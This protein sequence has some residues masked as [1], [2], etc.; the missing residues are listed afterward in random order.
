[1]FMWEENR[2]PDLMKKYMT[3]CVLCPRMC[4]VN[5]LAGQTGFC[6]ETAELV[7][8][9]AALHMWEEECI[10]GANG[11]GTVFFSGCNLGCV[12]CQ[13]YDISRAEAG[14]KVTVEKLA[15][16]FL[17][18]Q[19]QGAHNINL[20]TPTH[21]VPQIIEALKLAK[22][23][24]M[25]IPVVYNTGGYERAE[26]LQL[27]RGYVDIYLPDFKYVDGHSSGEYSHAPDYPEYAKRA[28]EEMFLQTGAFDIDET[29]GM[30]RRGVVVR[31][32]VLPGQVRNAKEVI[33]YLYETY[34]D[35]ILLSIM[36][37]Y[38]PMPQMK[39]NPL[40]GRKVTKREYDK[41]VDY[42]LELGVERGYIQE[43]EAALE[44]FIPEFDGEGV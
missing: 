16:I 22:E 7:V 6:K 23:K 2:E 1:M 42:A 11:S 33:R 17:K 12:F 15:Q 26:T 10:S 40:L 9:R 14:K 27:L 5:R 25:S 43:G 31:H 21:Y 30:L 24:G 3:D 19:G 35:S 41:V 29:T 20:V 8:A 37:Q 32:M 36:S 4:H 34:G 44:S 38:T 18:L 13:N 28:L 39:G